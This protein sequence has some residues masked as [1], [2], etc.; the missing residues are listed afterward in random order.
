VENLFVNLPFYGQVALA[1]V[2]YRGV[3]RWAGA[4]PRRVALVLISL[5]FLSKLDN[6]AWL[7]PLSIVYAAA[8]AALAVVVH[9]LAAVTA[10]RVTFLIGLVIALVAMLWFKYPVYAH[11]LFGGLRWIDELS[12][13][14][15][16]GLS[17][18]TFRAI[19]LLIHARA[20]RTRSVD[21]L[22]AFSYLLFF[23]PFISGPINRFAPYAAE[24][25]AASLPPLTYE[26]V[27]DCLL[28]ISVGILKI[29]L[30]GRFFYYHSPIGQPFDPA[31]VSAGELAAALASYYFYF[32]FDFAGYSDVAIAVARLFGISVPENFNVP[33]FS[34]N[35]QDFW[36]RW[37]ASLSQ[38]CRDH[39]FFNLLRALTKR[40]PRLPGVAASSFSIFVTFF[41]VGA[42]HGDALNWILYGLYHGAGM[43]IWLVYS[44]TFGKRFPDAY[45]TLS[46]NYLYRAASTLLTF[47]F[48]AFGLVITLGMG[49]LATLAARLG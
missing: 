45:Q 18:M 1:V 40:Y 38:W 7:V 5:Y 37:H 14:R 33:I 13:I 25:G 9:R 27:R 43:S 6:A 26:V 19:D 23:P 46:E 29:V 21:P 34:R 12:A 15:W 17:Y 16:L 49:P 42:W 22:V 35:L 31:T 39:I 30:L 2:L 11:A 36:S 24:Q 41:F 20:K 48:V 47:A 44:S 3:A 32:Y 4:V 10:K 28:R 8:F